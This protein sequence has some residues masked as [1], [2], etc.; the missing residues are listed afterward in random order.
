MAIGSTYK[1]HLVKSRR[2][3][4]AGYVLGSRS[5]IVWRQS[6]AVMRSLVGLAVAAS[7]IRS[8]HLSGVVIVV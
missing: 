3:V 1:K 6:P 8:L 2:V 4:P 5:V 7:R